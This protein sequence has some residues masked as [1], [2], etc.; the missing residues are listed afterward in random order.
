MAPNTTS[1]RSLL[2]RRS[3]TTSSTSTRSLLSQKILYFKTGAPS[4][5]KPILPT[6]THTSPSPYRQQSSTSPRRFLYGRKKLLHACILY[7]IASCILLFF[8]ILSISFYNVSKS[9]DPCFV[10]QNSLDNLAALLSVKRK[11][12]FTDSITRGNIG[13]ERSD[14]DGNGWVKGDDVEVNGNQL[15]DLDMSNNDADEDGE[16]GQQK[17]VGHVASLSLSSS[18]LEFKAE[19]PKIIHQQWKD[20]RIPQKFM[21]WRTKWLK[22]YPEPEY[23]HVLW[24]DQTGRD[25]I[26]KSYPWF[27]KIY[28]GYEHNINRADAARYFILHHYG[29]I[30]ADL[31]Y[32]PMINF[33]E[34]LPKN[35]VGLIESPY[36]WNEKT[37]NSLMSSPKNDPFWKDLFIVLEKNSKLDDILVMTGPS[38][39]DDAI[40]FSSQPTYVLP[41][42]N[43]H[44]VPIG[45]YSDA[46][47]TTVVGREVQFRVK[48]FSKQCGVYKDERCH[49]GKHHNTVTYRNVI[50][51]L[52]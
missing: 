42:E 30:Y 18:S 45:E 29:G 25:L 4:P 2:N 46:A 28:D 32:E 10:A 38:L 40:E 51:K 44:R 35:Q 11:I 41:C 16:E 20:E 3:I 26:E 8:I 13:N 21:K 36:Y 50:G 9:A 19:L 52:V 12:T 39:V 1:N 27:L 17:H 14:I 5:S 24:T 22:L 31:D 37:Q 33:Y 6:T 34:Y 47:I 15:D 7:A 43:F 48:P 49:F 23:K